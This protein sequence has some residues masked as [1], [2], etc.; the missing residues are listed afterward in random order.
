MTERERWIR[1]IGMKV[2][3]KEAAKILYYSRQKHEKVC[4]R[5]RASF[6]GLKEQKFCSPKCRILAYQKRRYHKL[7]EK[8]LQE[9][10]GA[11][12]QQ[13]EGVTENA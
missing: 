3:P 2:T 9:K 1:E 7:K 6:Y 13:S 12:H 10:L 8:Q 4:E 11:F 5:C